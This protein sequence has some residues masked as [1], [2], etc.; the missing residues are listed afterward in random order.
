M[1]RHD[2]NISAV[3]PVSD[4]LDELLI[5]FGSAAE[6]E[7]GR[8]DAMAQ[9]LSGSKGWRDAKSALGGTFASEV[10]GLPRSKLESRLMPD[11]DK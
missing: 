10:A 3:S 4:E 8:H 6:V 1:S 2:R 9:F 11:Q 7:T 5:A